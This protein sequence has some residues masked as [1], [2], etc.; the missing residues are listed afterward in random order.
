ME[1]I[2]KENFEAWMER[3]LDRLDRTDKKLEQVLKRQSCLD[4]DDLLDNQDLIDL[5]KVSHRTL[6]RFR[7]TG[8]LSYCN[9]KGKSY[10]KLTDVHKFIREHF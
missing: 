9:Y 7:S 2:T 5:L 10:Y 4:G 3:I 8:K 6:Q 1:N